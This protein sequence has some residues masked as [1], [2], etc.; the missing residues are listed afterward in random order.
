MK[1]NMLHTMKSTAVKEVQSRGA[2]FHHGKCASS[3]WHWQPHHVL[4][5][6]HSPR[7]YHCNEQVL[8]Q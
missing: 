4:I 5:L 6:L 2:L 7:N 1:E 8:H 3:S